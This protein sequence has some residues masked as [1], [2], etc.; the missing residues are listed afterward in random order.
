MGK[1]K[2]AW[3]M[4]FWALLVC[5]ITIAMEVSIEENEIQ[6]RWDLAE[7]DAK[8]DYF[9]KIPWEVVGLIWQKLLDDKFLIDFSS[10]NN[11][12]RNYGAKYR[13]AFFVMNPE[14]KSEFE[15]Y[16]KMEL[17]DYSKFVTYL[18]EKIEKIQKSINAPF[19]VQKEPFEVLLIQ[20][21]SPFYGDQR[22]LS[23]EEC[24]SIVEK[25]WHS[26]FSIC[27]AL[28]GGRSAVVNLAETF[29]IDI[30]DINSDYPHALSSS[31]RKDPF[32]G[33]I[34]GWNGPCALLGRRRTLMLLYI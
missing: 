22:G 15:E 21:Y 29:T 3:C 23:K 33:K 9:A 6:K 7:L 4:Y 8:G 2:L 19:L 20:L 10:T 5:S 24:L 14:L 26:R 27:F 11:F 34:C 31:I 13:F 1:L 12:Y 16:E 30:G 28:S 25:G 18:N 17:R 32:Y